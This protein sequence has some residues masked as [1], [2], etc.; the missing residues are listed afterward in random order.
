MARGGLGGVA[1]HVDPA[2]HD[3][4]REPDAGIAVDGHVALLVH[5]GC[6]VAG[7]ALDGHGDVRV[8]ADGEAVLAAGVVTVQDWP[9]GSVMQGRVEVADRAAG[10]VD[11]DGINR[12]IP[13][14]P[15]SVRGFRVLSE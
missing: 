10:Q 4:F 2:G 12:L 11:A 3:V 13:A 8:D 14:L 9:S 7:V 1:L 5:P 15:P 6:V